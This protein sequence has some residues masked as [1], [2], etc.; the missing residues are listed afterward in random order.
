MGISFFGLSKKY[1]HTLP[2][3]DGYWLIVR[4]DGEGCAPAPK[5]IRKPDFGK[6]QKFRG[7]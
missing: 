2:I 5:N 4:R 7:W 6:P 3:H 1:S